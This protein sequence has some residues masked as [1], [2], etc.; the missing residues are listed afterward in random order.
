MEGDAGVDARFGLFGDGEGAVGELGDEEGGGDAFAFCLFGV[1][2]RLRALK[3]ST[4]FFKS[5]SS[6]SLDSNSL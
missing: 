1:A 5:S 2:S 4:S 6:V 3:F